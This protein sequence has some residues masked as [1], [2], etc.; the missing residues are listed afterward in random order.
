[1]TAQ[2]T[3]ET[4]P[5][6]A[7]A[8]ST[9][10]WPRRVRRTAGVLLFVI[11]FVLLGGYFYLRN[12]QRA[13]RLIEGVVASRLGLN[14]HIESADVTI[15]NGIGLSDV[16]LLPLNPPGGLVEH[17]PVFRA[18]QVRVNYRIWPLLT[19]GASSVTI[20]ADEPVLRL[21]EDVDR[22]HWEIQDVFP[23][24][25]TPPPVLPGST[26]TPATKD[27]NLPQ[28]L[29]RSGRIERAE[30]LDGTRT[31]L[32]G[33][34]LE[35]SLRPDML[36]GGY[37]WSLQTRTADG[38]GP[39]FGGRLSLLSSTMAEADLRGL[40]LQTLPSLM[41]KRVRDFLS[42][43]DLSGRI[44]VPAIQVSR[45]AT[46]QPGFSID[47]A[48]RH[49]RFR[50]TPIRWFAPGELRNSQR[51]AVLKADTIADHA[52][53]AR[54]ILRDRAATAEQSV[55]LENA[56]AKVRF[57]HDKI[58]V[59]S[60]SASIE[61]NA[62]EISGE[63]GGYQPTS[64]MSL[65]IRSPD[66]MPLRLSPDLKYIGALP[67]PARE[68]Y[69]RFSPAGVG[70]VDLVVSRES[71]QSE[72]R[73]T[74]GLTL[75]DADIVFEGFRYPVRNAT[76]AVLFS[77]DDAK[78]QQR[79]TL[80][81][82]RCFGS[83]GSANQ[84]TQVSVSGFVQPLLQNSHVVID[85]RADDIDTNDDR[86]IAALPPGVATALRDLNVAGNDAPGRILS[87][88][89]VKIERPEG[90][91]TMWSYDTDVQITDGVIRPK[92]F[93][94][95]IDQV[96][97]NVIYRS[98]YVEVSN[99]VARAGTGLLKLDGTIATDARNVKP[100]VLNL[101]ATGVAVDPTLVK[102]LPEGARK[103]LNESRLK[104][105]LD[106]NGRLLPGP[107]GTFD[108]DLGLQLRDG[109][110]R[111]SDVGVPV[112]G[113]AADA[114]LTPD[115]LDVTSV[116]AR[117]GDDQLAGMAKLNLQG[118]PRLTARMWSPGVRVDPL[119]VSEFPTQ[120]QEAIATLSLTGDVAFDAN[121]NTALPVSI[122]NIGYDLLLK[123][124]K[125]RVVPKFF[126]CGFDLTNG[127][128]RVTPDLITVQDLAAR[129][130]KGDL[131]IN[132]TVA[133]KN[134]Y[135]FDLTMKA[136]GIEVDGELAAAMPGAMAQSLRDVALVGPVDLD[137]VQFKSTPIEPLADGAST[138]VAITQFNMTLKLTD[139]A[140]TLGVPLSQVN[141]N[142]DFNGSSVGASLRTLD[143]RLSF[144]RFKLAGLQ[145]QNATAHLSLE[146]ESGVEHG[147][148]LMIRQGD[149][150]LAG[151][152]LA[153]EGAVFLDQLPMTYRGEILLRDAD[154]SQL[155]LTSKTPL[156]GMLSASLSIE[157]AVR[158]SINPDAPVRRRGRGDIS[159][160]G[161]KLAQL[162]LLLGVTQIASLSLP[163]SGGFNNAQATYSLQDE[164]L[165]FDRL[166]L[167]SNEMLIDGG[168]SLD[169]QKKTIDLSFRTD[170]SGRQLPV[171]GSLLRATRREL[172][173]I[174]VRGSLSEPAI[175]AGMMPTIIGTVDEVLGAD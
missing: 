61:G 138:P 39:R 98:G 168:G 63:L 112:E 81:D 6:P 140:L 151:G 38:I 32:G 40:Q 85:I 41:P 19:R 170:T 78:S 66:G 28:L 103:V 110:A 42:E 145:A 48:M 164:V 152:R 13:A 135:A 127:E 96:K 37:L 9:R 70:T 8:G 18:R 172:L 50:A 43:L 71:G 126:P 159:L 153:G 57:T 36:V 2:I 109:V 116:T 88:V 11:L 121:L 1:M 139:N 106:V 122:E 22:N 144:D 146:G 160:T 105:N 60:L 125:A 25:P 90:Y 92:A 31:E 161:D 23:R 83:T 102:A 82:I 56:D 132:G 27:L 65:R 86:L 72:P 44:D 26:T 94:Y 10:S 7:P 53:L 148:R 113:I 111:F 133:P 68:V 54:R 29:I 130:V 51:M 87:D 74:G 97:A 64:P 162:P 165:S 154:I 12:G 52:I 108:Y 58:F 131:V 129:R 77:W 79:L 14:V 173:Q 73:L 62:L 134:E 46:G 69:Y 123:P 17:E 75:I 99:A 95:P 89:L 107:G 35:G 20:I 118:E 147:R 141:G 137:V 169:F 4:S 45:T 115:E 143:A 175:T 149:L 157:G 119:M 114:K 76:G 16:R 142:V 24:R 150:A 84:N 174:R 100:S 124:I 21:V 49:V 101:V 156:T 80:E 128:V 120:W 15:F 47:L 163:F 33:V 34:D 166:Q 67:A 104:G 93:D 171:I 59:Q 158:D 3:P 5:T 155:A 55:L 136:R 117:R 30:V 91:R 167:R